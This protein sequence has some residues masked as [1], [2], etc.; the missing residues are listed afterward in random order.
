MEQAVPLTSILTGNTRKR[1][2]EEEV[3]E[4]NKPDIFKGHVVAPPLQT[5]GA[6][7]NAVALRGRITVKRKEVEEEEVEQYDDNDNGDDYDISVQDPI[8]EDVID[9]DLLKESVDQPL[10]IPTKATVELHS[11]RLSPIGNNVKVRSIKSI[12][13]QRKPAKNKIVIDL[14]DD[15]D[16]K[17]FFNGTGQTPGDSTP[18]LQAKTVGHPINAKPTKLKDIFSN[19][20]KPATVD[21][22]IIPAN[23]NEG[24]IIRYH[25]VSSLSSLDAPLPRVQLTEP[26]DTTS[27]ITDT[28]LPL[29][30]RAQEKN[31]TTVFNFSADEYSAL[32]QHC[33]KTD[34]DSKGKEIH[35][36]INKDTVKTASMWPELFSPKRV[37]EVILEKTL[38]TNVRNWILNALSK[39]RKPTTRNKLLKSYKQQ[40]GDLDDFIVADNMLVDNNLEDNDL[41]EEFVPLM[42]LYGEGIGKN[43]LISTIVNELNGQIYEVNASQNRA[44]RDILDVLSEYCTSYYVKDKAVSGVVLISDADVVFREHDKFFWLSIEKLL[45]TS[46]K[47]IIITAR[48]VNFI[49][50]NLQEICKMEG[51]LF[52][53]KRVTPRTVAAF[54]KKY[55]ER[56][57]LTL[58]DWNVLQL[59]AER[60]NSNIRKCLLDLQF[61]FSSGNKLMMQDDNSSL[62]TGSAYTCGSLNE[63]ADLVDLMSY[64]AVLGTNTA[65]RSSLRDPLD[66]TLK[67]ST[68]LANYNSP[69]AD[70][71]FKWT[72]DYMLDYRLH[73]HND[74]QSR[75][76]PFELDIAKDLERKLVTDYGPICHAKHAIPTLRHQRT[77]NTLEHYLSTRVKTQPFAYTSIAEMYHSSSALLRRSTRGSSED[78]LSLFKDFN[79][80]NNNNNSNKNDGSV[81]TYNAVMEDIIF[82]LTCAG[83]R[84]VLAEYF[85][86]VLEVAKNE[87]KAKAYNRRLFAERSKAVPETRLNYAKILRELGENGQFRS[88]WFK[89]SPGKLISCWKLKSAAK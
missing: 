33:G 47:P 51:S 23:I 61:W 29:K 27:V 78:I 30:K 81:S 68:V 28:T 17:C 83:K 3:V 26:D 86:Y 70:D 32:N 14:D 53:A 46:R 69:D 45:L 9:P 31:P 7:R 42:I 57:G 52:Q 12:L 5:K 13:M 58:E 56:L 11:S 66:H 41:P 48:D 88:V 67:S 18:R 60:N 82:D 87:E 4:D 63:A 89:S 85:P 59:L 2:Y 50:T 71:R 16:D 22:G 19:F 1:R 15:T 34:L 6:T 62:S 20:P 72:N 79:G 55:C 21:T 75:L 37:S 35:Y 84:T 8:S 80:Y 49:P 73:L 54:L 44:K 10:S 65:Y 38:K 77:I 25:N 74:L 36:S 39:L 64:C 43:T 24:P 40:F 76:F